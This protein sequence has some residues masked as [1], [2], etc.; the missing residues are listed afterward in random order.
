MGERA[1][2]QHRRRPLGR[3]LRRARSVLFWIGVLLLAV[4]GIYFSFANYPLFGT[5]VVLLL[6][7]VTG[8]SEQRRRTK[9]KALVTARRRDR[10]RSRD[11][12]RG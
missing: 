7:A 11:L 3:G 4:F 6:L 5:A 8:Y 1:T 2:T 12:H 10:A 9:H